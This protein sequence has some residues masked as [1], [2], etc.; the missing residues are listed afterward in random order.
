MIKAKHHAKA[1]GRKKN[2]PNALTRDVRQFLAHV[3]DQNLDQIMK[4]LKALEP[5]QRL[6]IMDRLL[7]YIVPKLTTTQLD[8]TR[9]AKAHFANLFPFE[10]KQDH[11]HIIEAEVIQESSDVEQES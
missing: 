11:Q 9:D 8:A 4:D 6:I 7:A 1:G 5:Y 2:T 3:I 10:L